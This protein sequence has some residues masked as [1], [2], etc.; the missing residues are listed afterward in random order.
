MDQPS[1]VKRKKSQEDLSSANSSKKARKRVRCG[2]FTTPTRNTKFP[3]RLSY[4]C[5][6][7]HRRKQKVRSV[8]DRSFRDTYLCPK[9]DRQIPCSH[10]V[11]RK[12]PELCKAYSPGKPDQDVHSR[13]A[14][15]ESVLEAAVPQLW[16]QS[17]RNFNRRSTSPGMEDDAGIPEGNDNMT[18]VF[19]RGSWIGSSAVG[20]IASPIVLEQVGF[21][22]STY[23]LMFTG[24]RSIISSTTWS[25]LS[26]QTLQPMED[27]ILLLRKV[28]EF[29]G[30]TL[31][32]IISTRSYRIA[33][34]LLTRL[35][36]CCKSYPQRT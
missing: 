1:S 29:Q 31:L 10:C 18:G 12:V 24:F 26:T 28:L 33:V 6:E 8:T 3:P 23:F 25:L 17:D 15:I 9:C 16:S 36:S 11:S 13:L 21:T 4:S 2:S 7:C 34:F 30:N 27:Y 20:S 35:L 32:R 22:S 19:Y 14:R 5:G